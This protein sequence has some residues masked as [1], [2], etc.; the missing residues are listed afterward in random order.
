MSE[1]LNDWRGPR[2]DDD[3][4][5]EVDGEEKPKLPMRIADKLMESRTI[6]LADSVCSELARDIIGRLL[7]L[8]GDDP[9]AP[10]D[11]FINSPGGSVDSGYAIYDMIRF[12]SAPVRCIANGLCASAA[13]IILLAAAKKQRMSL[14]NSRFMIHQPSGGA[15]G[16]VADIKIEADEIL[17]IR[18]KINELIAVET[19]KSVD[20]VDDA[21]R[22]NTWMD[23]AE[24]KKYG[25]L[26]KILKSRGDLK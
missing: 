19:G 4:E 13:V 25:L 16:S 24:A 2:A 12:V 20:E 10:I 5:P 18:R 14:P 6:M 17:K 7:V 11:L 21:T 8:D 22:R 15:R 26:S 9:K 23:V 1:L 3:D